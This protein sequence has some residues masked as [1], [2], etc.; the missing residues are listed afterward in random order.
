MS[1]PWPPLP[2]VLG[3]PDTS[4]HL[5]S[6]EPW[7]LE[8]CILFSL[9]PK[10]FYQ[11]F[12]T[13]LLKPLLIAYSVQ[14]SDHLLQISV[15]SSIYKSDQSVLYMNF[16]HSKFSQWRRSIQNYLREDRAPTLATLPT[17]P[18]PQLS[19]PADKDRV[20]HPRA[21]ISCQ[22]RKTYL[23]TVFKIFAKK[24]ELQARQVSHKAQYLFLL[25]A[26]RRARK[27]KKRRR[28]CTS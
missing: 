22:G 24:T 27:K 9:S 8:R 2:G 11:I 26:G 5:R 16:L 19:S 15:L 1:Q 13:L 10:I 25:M 20:D 17:L 21:Q 6:R 12:L 7:R 28:S 3:L 4:G 18:N 23:E 14:L